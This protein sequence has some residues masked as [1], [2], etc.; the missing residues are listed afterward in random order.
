[1][2]LAGTMKLTDN[3]QVH[4]TAQFDRLALLGNTMLVCSCVGA[5]QDIKAL[6]AAINSRIDGHIELTPVQLTLGKTSPIVSV[7]LPDAGSYSM[8]MHRLPY[9]T[10]HALAVSR[11]PGL[12]LNASPAN[13]W[14]ALKSERFTTPL[15]RS[16]LPYL[17]DELVER[18]LLED[19]ACLDCSC[20]FL[21]VTTKELDSIV[22]DGLKKGA[23][24][25]KED[26][27]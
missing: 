5:S 10:V 1:M 25:V 8:Y 27:A 21:S 12:L 11:R 9:G 19:L 20:K 18:E 2:P 22:E 26:A 24:E 3:E 13:L 6:R 7:A 14:A 4:I 15:L 23:I 17:G 16:W